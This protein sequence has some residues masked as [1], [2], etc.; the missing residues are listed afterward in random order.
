MASETTSNVGVA[1]AGGW[2][3]GVPSTSEKTEQMGEDELFFLPK[4][5][6]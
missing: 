1:G 6:R 2:G 3:A 4:A 5:S